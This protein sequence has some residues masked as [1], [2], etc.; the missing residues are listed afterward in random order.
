MR[1]IVTGK[2]RSGKS[3]ALHRLTRTALTATW[4]NVLIA[5]GKSVELLRYADD[6]LH[7]Y[8]EDEVEDFAEASPP[9]PI[10]SPRA[11]RRC[12]AAAS[13]RRCPEIRAS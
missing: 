8:G 6:R 3:S 13:L 2:S 1:L 11:T 9:P 5:D 7:V 10:T 4:A 12:A